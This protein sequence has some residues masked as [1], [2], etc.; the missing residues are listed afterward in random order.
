MYSLFEMARE[1]VLSKKEERSDTSPFV[2][3]HSS[4]FDRTHFPAIPNKEYAI[5]SFVTV[6]VRYSTG[7]CR[8]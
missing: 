6:L 1:C 7:P 2:S 4:F 3:E 5:G 8:A